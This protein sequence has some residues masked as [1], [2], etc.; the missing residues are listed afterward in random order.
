MLSGEAK[1]EK[2][3]MALQTRVPAQLAMR[4]NDTAKRKKQVADSLKE[5]DAKKR[6]R[7]I[8]LEA[9]IVQAGVDWSRSK[10][11]VISLCIAIFAM[12]L[13]WFTNGSPFLTVCAGIA[14]GFG[15]PRWI[16]NYLRKR[17]IKQFLAELPSAVDIIVRGIKAGIPLGDCLRNIATESAEPLKSEF[18]GIVDAQAMGLSI[19]EAVERIV[20]R[21]PTAEA[22]FFAIVINIQQK[23]GGNLA[24]ALQ[25]LSAVLRDRKKMRGKIKAMSSEAKASAGIIG[26]LPPIVASL[27]YLTSPDYMKLL[28]ITPSG[29]IVLA[30]CAF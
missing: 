10:F 12:L 26:A 4:V 9:R 20:D 25:N 7:K 3:K 19:A 16:L 1:A 28:F 13:T 6:S 11:Y 29:H 30:V 17:R 24:E 5:L 15:M 21:V 27:V 23:A 18:R 8:T 22:N 2:R 14:G